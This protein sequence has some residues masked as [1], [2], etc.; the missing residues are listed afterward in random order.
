LNETGYV[1][2]LLVGG[3][4]SRLGQLASD[5]A[6]CLI[7]FCGIP[8]LELILSK[9]FHEH[10][11][12]V[13]LV[14]GYH[15]DLIERYV[16]EHLLDLYPIIMIREA[17]GTAPAIRQALRI[18]SSPDIL[19]LNGDTI[20]DIHYGDVMAYHRASQYPMTLVSTDLREVPN[21]GAILVDTNNI[22]H[23]FEENEYI[24]EENKRHLY[25]GR[26][27][28]N[29]GCYC[30]RIKDVLPFLENA[31]G[32]SFELDVLPKLIQNVSVQ[33]YTNG[34]KTFIDFGVP[35]RLEQAQQ[36]EEIL[37]KIYYRRS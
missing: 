20:L 6:K 19:C 18:A 32:Q 10:C 17:D 22:V 34:T 33:I 35:A 13:I 29:C 14:T 26:R 12:Q 5:N 24:D 9:L 25:S 2:S 37:R 8:F 28:S 21:S 7:N 27:V 4:A 36:Q 23:S 30:I 15:A 1:A 3:R 16:K 11:Q 31:G